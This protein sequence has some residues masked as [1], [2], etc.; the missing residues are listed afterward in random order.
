MQNI[1]ELRDEAV[2]FDEAEGSGLLR[3]S[4]LSAP[5]RVAA[6]T[7]QGC[8]PYS[9]PEPSASC[10]EASNKEVAGSASRIQFGE[11]HTPVIIHGPRITGY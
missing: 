5:D 11:Q 10:G 6:A 3:A 8:S 7:F 4:Q 9:S 1:G 2:M